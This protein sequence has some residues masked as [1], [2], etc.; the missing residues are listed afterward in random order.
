[1]TLLVA[2]LSALCTSLAAEPSEYTVGAGDV[3][4]IVVHGHDFERRE[5]LVS[6]AGLVSFPYVGHVL[7]QGLT[8]FQAEDAIEDSLRDGYLVDPQ[9]TVTV[10][11]YGAK[12]HVLGAVDNEGQ[13]T[14]NGNSTTVR[15]VLSTAG[16]S[17]AGI[18]GRVKLTRTNGETTLIPFASLEG[19]EGNT[20]LRAG[21]VLEVSQGH[22]VFLAGEVE[23]PGAISY[24]DGIT[25]S[26]ALI[27]A[28]GKTEFARLAGAYVV[29]NGE[30]TKVNL[31][32]VLKGKDADF[33][34]Q[35]GDR[36][37][38]PVSAL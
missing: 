10:Q 1:M 30:Q 7:L 28:G 11:E 25:V 3:M 33:V 19:P 13:Q 16:T 5:F 18:G 21:D 24:T 20:V 14:L 4:N 32:R 9:V 37:V 15:Q 29:R 8:T 26:Q 2:I 22:S 36:I 35:P 27:R 12:V 34:L 31:K 23:K 6:S 38:V 17:K